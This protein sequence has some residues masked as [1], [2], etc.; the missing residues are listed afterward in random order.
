[1]KLPLATA[2]IRKGYGGTFR[3]L[4][5]GEILE[6]GDVEIGPTFV[7]EVL[8]KYAGQAVKPGEAIIRLEFD[9]KW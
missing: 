1:M 3:A 8:E 4:K 2:K 5:P 6:E 9:T 7:N